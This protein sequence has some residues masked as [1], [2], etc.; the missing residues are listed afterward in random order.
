MLPCQQA[1]MLDEAIEF[2]KL[3]LPSSKA[4]EIALIN[5]TWDTPEKLEIFID[6]LKIAA[7]KLTSHNR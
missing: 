2:E 6:K 3:I 5:I 7:H 1:M 4:N